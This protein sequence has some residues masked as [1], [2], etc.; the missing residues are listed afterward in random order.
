[1][2]SLAEGMAAVG[3]GRSERQSAGHLSSRS[4][5][6][7]SRASPAVACYLCFSLFQDC[8][9]SFRGGALQIQIQEVFEFYAKSI[10]SFSLGRCQGWLSK[11]LDEG[12]CS[13]GLLLLHPQLSV[14]L[15]GSYEGLIGI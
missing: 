7:L 2:A 8:M 5:P 6:A 1:M 9:E 10:H 12:S 4:A 3:D 14:Q 11:R 15:W 13:D